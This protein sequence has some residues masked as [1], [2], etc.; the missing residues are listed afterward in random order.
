MQ[1]TCNTHLLL[2]SQQLIGEAYDL[3]KN[4]LGMNH[5]EMTEVSGVDMYFHPPLHA[6]LPL[7]LLLL[8]LLLLTGIQGMEQGRAGLLPD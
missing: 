3:M 1:Y 7:L 8:L 6:Y 2:N 5:D 4:A